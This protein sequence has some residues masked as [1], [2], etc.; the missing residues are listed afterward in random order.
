MPTLEESRR[1]VRE[2]LDRQTQEAE[3]SDILANLQ[4]EIDKHNALKDDV[5]RYWHKSRKDGGAEDEGD[6]GRSKQ[7]MKFRFKDGATNDRKRR[8]RTHHDRH[9]RH[10]KRSK[11][12]YPASP[13][14]GAGT[15]S[16]H[17]FPREPVDIDGPAAGSGNAAFRDSLFD[18]LAND[19]GAQY[20]ESVYSQPIH[21]Y[22]RPAVTTP[23]GQL[24]QMNDEEY[25]AYVKTKMWER[26]HP[27][28]M[29]ERERSERQ[30]REEEEER[31][32][33]RE[34]FIRRKEQAAWERAA[35]RG[36]RRGHGSEEGEGEYAFA[37]EANMNLDTQALPASE[38]SKA[39]SRYLAAWDRLKLELLDERNASQTSTQSPSKRIPWPVLDS[40]PVLRANIE[41][42]IL[43]A[44]VDAGRT[45]LQILKAERV[46]WHPDKIQQRF[47]G[48]VDE[49]T[50]KLVTGVF[51]V[52]DTVFEEERKR[53]G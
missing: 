18:A 51:Q 17:P 49:G 24:E 19:E 37:G 4:G 29:L 40:K 9:T 42:F 8:H 39:W 36:T 27:E 44:P 53:V 41:D 28:I 15:E 45:R 12:D 2:A 23:Q 33:R 26:K 31:T 32:R 30:R 43:H 35:R 11:S 48:A 50:M 5:K 1:Q 46:R 6:P 52:V 7:S 25:A 14:D 21:V 16:A 10:H 38:Y 47:A 20:W 3:H 13:E 22:P 34:E